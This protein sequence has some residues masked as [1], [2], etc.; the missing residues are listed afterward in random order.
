MKYI[1]I[2]LLI[3]VFG[4]E[5]YCDETVYGTNSDGTT[6]EECVV[7]NTCENKH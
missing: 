6:Y 1:F 7:C 5:S 4:C 2:L 3:G